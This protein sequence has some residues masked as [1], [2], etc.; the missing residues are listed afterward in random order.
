MAGTWHVLG[1]GSL[2]G[3]WATR[4]F[5]A[6]VPLRIGTLSKAL[7]TYGGYLA[8]SKPV[9]EL[10]RSRARTMIYSTGLPPEIGRAHV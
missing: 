2:G 1:A 5:R 10:M 9:I 4:L 8:A 7:G 3:L 6:G